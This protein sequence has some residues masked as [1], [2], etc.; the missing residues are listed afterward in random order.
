[1]LLPQ[2]PP[3]EQA[4]GNDAEDVLSFLSVFDDFGVGLGI[5]GDG[6]DGGFV[7]GGRG[8]VE[9]RL[10]GGRKLCFEGGNGLVVGGGELAKGRRTLRRRRE[11]GGA[12][13]GNVAGGR[14]GEGGGRRENETVAEVWRSR[15]DMLRT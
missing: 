3:D 1:M 14:A 13:G 7:G 15:A 10:L 2:V 4:V 8:S 12:D 11:G 9:F 5:V 6:E